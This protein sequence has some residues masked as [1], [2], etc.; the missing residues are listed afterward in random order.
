M[1]LIEP[2]SGRVLTGLVQEE[3]DVSLAVCTANDRVIV[4]K[5][6]IASRKLLPE[7]LMPR[8]LLQGMSEEEIC[9]LFAFLMTRQPNSPR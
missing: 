2:S 6:Q 4:A 8:G 1:T 7:S 9:D 3:N 5:K